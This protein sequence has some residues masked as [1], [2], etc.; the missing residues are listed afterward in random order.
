MDM[1]GEIHAPSRSPCH[2]QVHIADSARSC[3]IN[4][5]VTAPHADATPSHPTDPSQATAS[6][7]ASN[8][9]PLRRAPHFHIRRTED[10]ATSGLADAHPSQPGMNVRLLLVLRR[11]P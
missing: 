11:L 10:E 7:G 6:A 3:S 9:A 4:L 5:C 2:Y 8:R 1:D